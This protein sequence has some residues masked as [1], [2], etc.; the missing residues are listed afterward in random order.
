VGLTKAIAGR[1]IYLDS[2]IFIYAVERHPVFSFAVKQIFES[3]DQGRTEAVT[4]ELTL[5][6]VLVKPNE[7]NLKRQKEAYIDI[8]T[9][10]PSLEAV[11][12]T[13]EILIQS[14]A[15]RARTGMKLP[16]AI[17]VT[18]SLER[19]C[20]VFITND[21]GIKTPGILTRLLLSD[22]VEK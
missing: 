6:E 17:H 3:I 4:S 9:G 19:Q 7:R 1:R 22:L 20:H 16:D 18:T 12:T 15:M 21:A 5:A 13:R 10:T 14:A 11:A 8:I 2:N